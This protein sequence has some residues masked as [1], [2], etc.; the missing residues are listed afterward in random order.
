MKTVITPQPSRMA[1]IYVYIDLNIV[2]AGVVKHPSEWP[3]SGYN[4]IQ[5][6]KRKDVLINY[7]RL[8]E[9]LGFDTYDKVKKAHRKWV[10]SCLKNGDNSREDK[11]TGGIAVGSK[12]FIGDIKAIMGGMVA[13]RRPM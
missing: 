4:E 8:R 5:E 7:E 13:G 1:I 9:L 12:G 10:D 3:C 6:P 11:W 2:R